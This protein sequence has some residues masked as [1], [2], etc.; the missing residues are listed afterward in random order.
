MRFKRLCIALLVLG[1]SF[2]S[3]DIQVFANDVT[4]EN[5]ITNIDVSSISNQLS[6]LYNSIGNKLGVKPNYIKLLHSLSDN[7]LEYLEEY[8]NIYRDLA[9]KECIKLQDIDIV[10]QKADFLI[11]RDSELEVAS[12]YYLPDAL[13]SL[14]YDIVALMSQR[15][16]YNRGGMQIYFDA[17]QDNVKKDIVF[18]ESV[19]LYTGESEETVNKFYSAYEKIMYDKQENESIIDEN[20]DFKEKY[21]ETLSNI[22][23]TNLKYLAILM[24]DNVILTKNDNIEN[25]KT[26]Y[27]MPYKLNYT[28]REN[29]MIAATSLTG[30]V[31]Y[32]WG[33]GHAGASNIDGI[34]PVW[35]LCNQVYLLDDNTAYKCIKPS[36]SWCMLHGTNYD[37]CINSESFYSIEDY[38]NNR[39]EILSSKGLTS[40]KCMSIL[41]NIETQEGY[42]DG[43]RLDGLDCSGYVSWV[44]NQITDNYIIDSTAANFRDVECFKEVSLGSEMLPG[45]IFAWKTHVVMIIGKVSNESKA[46]VTIEQTPNVV[47]FGV[48]Y[49]GGATEEDIEYAKQVATEANVLFGNIDC[50]QDKVGCYCIDRVKYYTEII[51]EVEIT[52]ELAYIVRF[53]DEFIDEQTLLNN[54]NMGIIDMNAL[55]IIR[56][57]LTKLPLSYVSGFDVYEGDLFLKDSV[58]SNIGINIENILISSE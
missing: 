35:S 49:Y 50:S 8:P 47:K 3:A 24:K 54:Y 23:I 11:N 30:K 20:G 21:T 2:G 28:S 46:Y 44:F 37:A 14:S 53:K 42:I 40:E 6:V 43:H 18:Y 1:V 57:T 39:S 32:I 27:T 56:Y 29:L 33:G 36:G 25:V 41:G 51:D 45:D 26:E 31:R 15:Y 9:L 58:S 34:N 4:H 19:L 16:N 38:V 48:I 7:K 12:A 13:Y 52:N 55:D 10:Y 17:L 5:I 22:G